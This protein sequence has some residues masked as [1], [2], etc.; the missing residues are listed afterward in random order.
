[1]LAYLFGWT[2]VDIWTIALGIGIVMMGIAL[3]MG[4]F[5]YLFGR[6]E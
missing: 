4:L 1:M 2:L 3:A 5:N 6:D